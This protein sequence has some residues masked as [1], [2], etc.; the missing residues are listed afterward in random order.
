MI[1]RIW[2]DSLCSVGDT[3]KIF[4]DMQGRY[5]ADEWEVGDSIEAIVNNGD[6]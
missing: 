2:S 3:E 1:H 5:S 4:G 6:E